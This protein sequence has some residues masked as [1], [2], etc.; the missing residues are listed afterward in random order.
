MTPPAGTIDLGELPSAW[1]P[2]PEPTPP[3]TGRWH[4]GNR[5]TRRLAAAVVAAG[6]V[7]TTAVAAGAEPPGALTLVLTVRAV[8]HNA[9]ADEQHLYVFKEL[10]DGETVVAAYRLADG[11]L[12]W[13]TQ[14]AGAGAGIDRYGGALVVAAYRSI[15]EVGYPT[16]ETVF[17]LDAATGRLL[18]TMLGWPVVLPRHRSDR[19]LIQRQ[20]IPADP[21]E[22]AASSLTMV[23]LTTGEQVWRMAPDWWLHEPASEVLLTMEERTL[24]SFDLITGERLAARSVSIPAPPDEF[25]GDLVTV[26]GSL[27]LVVE[28]VDGE[29]ATV[30]FDATTLQRRWT[31]PD[32]RPAHEQYPWPVSC[33]ELLCRLSSA[34]PP[35][36][37]DP[38]SGRTLW[39]ADW[40]R[41]WLIDLATGD[42]VLDFGRWE[43]FSWYYARPGLATVTVTYATET[44]TWVGTARPDLS[45][46]DPLGLIEGAALDESGYGTYCQP[47]PGHVVCVTNVETRDPEAGTTVEVWRLP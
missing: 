7:L 25:H 17:A 14:V 1:R 33:G 47:S 45:G 36:G 39:T 34:D 46:I 42:P 24:T 5:R 20:E 31:A 32:W 41:S 30:A 18:W 10:R 4:W 12:A 15:A 40:L 21:V 37:V 13:R 38:A 44:G 26:A 23:D 43:P 27:V 22:P 19:L 35:Q 2:T 16:D 9:I 11:A 6:L 28:A 8:D 3:P 29:P